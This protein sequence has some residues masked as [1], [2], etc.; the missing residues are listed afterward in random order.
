[1]IVIALVKERFVTPGRPV[2]LMDAVKQHLRNGIRYVAPVKLPGSQTAKR[3]VRGV[4][5]PLGRG[6]TGE[7]N[8]S[9]LGG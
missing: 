2:A 3:E 6:V 8:G 9:E 1:M 4:W 7:S 5:N